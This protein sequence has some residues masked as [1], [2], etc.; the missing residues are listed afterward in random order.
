MNKLNDEIFSEIKN[1][2]IDAFKHHIKSKRKWLVHIPNGRVGSCD[3]FSKKNIELFSVTPIAAVIDYN[4][5]T[6]YFV[7][8]KFSNSRIRHNWDNLYLVNKNLSNEFDFIS[9]TN[10]LEF[11]LYD[12]IEEDYCLNFKVSL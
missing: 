12:R 11:R 3:M 9:F 1:H 2:F 8:I 5:N 6:D 7:Q 10:D 4:H